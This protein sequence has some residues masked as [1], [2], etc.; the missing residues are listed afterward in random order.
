MFY[1]GRQLASPP[2]CDDAHCTYTR[3]TACEYHYIPQKHILL[4]D[5]MSHNNK[6]EAK[7]YSLSPRMLFNPLN[8]QLNPSSPNFSAGYLNFAHDIKKT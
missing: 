1:Q 7:Y 2:P 6:S 8:A 3:F 5:S 4:G